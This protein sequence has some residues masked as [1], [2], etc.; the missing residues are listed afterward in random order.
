MRD[1]AKVKTEQIDLLKQVCATPDEAPSTR[2]RVIGGSRLRCPGIDHS[3][4]S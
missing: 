2:L 1:V 3:F 4:G